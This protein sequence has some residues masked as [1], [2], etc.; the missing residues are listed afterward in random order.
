MSALGI[1]LALAVT[2]QTS[3]ETPPVESSEP[4]APILS[5][6]SPPEAPPAPP[7][8][9]SPPPKA[10][11]P[12]K[13]A[14]PA[15]EAPLDEEMPSVRADNGDYG[16]QF[17][18]G[19]LAS[20]AADG[21]AR[22][23]SQG[24]TLLLTQIGLKKVYSEEW[25]MILSF[26]TAFQRLKADGI[27][28]FESDASNDVGLDFGIGFEYHF[29]IWRRI[30]PFVGGQLGLGYTNP[31]GDDNSVL[32]IGFGPSLGVEYYVLDRVSLTAQ[33]L[34]SFQIVRLFG[35][36][37]GTGFQTLSGGAMNLTFYF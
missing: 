13:K 17:R 34:L 31:T 23:I 35:E 12:A 2:A 30:S 15:S 10:A 24:G 9:A 28:G 14:P 26:G 5:E 7:P 11:P 18:F 37:T 36:G 25:M 4:G 6:P 21:N 16:L 22:Q 20:L 3:G 8:K 19:G 1:M 29:R 27:A 32:G 33:Y